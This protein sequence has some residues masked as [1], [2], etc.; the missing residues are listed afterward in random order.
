MEFR[1]YFMPEGFI[2]QILDKQ[3]KNIPLTLPFSEKVAGSAPSLGSFWVMFACPPCACVCFRQIIRFI[4]TD[5]KKCMFGKLVTL[6]CPKGES[7]S[8]C[9]V[10][11]YEAL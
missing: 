2:D 3:T 9:V 1:N 10:S 5:Q 6:N 8:D 11:L 7:E 4:P